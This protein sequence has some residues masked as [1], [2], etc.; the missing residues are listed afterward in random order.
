ML[1]WLLSASNH[2]RSARSGT[3]HYVHGL[4]PGPWRDSGNL[5]LDGQ[6]IA[7]RLD[8][9]F[10]L[11]T[12]GYRTVVR[13]QQTLEAT[14]ACSYELVLEPER[15]RLRCLSVFAGG[16]LLRAADTVDA[17]AAAAAAVHFPQQIDRPPAPGHD[18]FSAAAC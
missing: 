12:G 10:R 5:F 2:T 18:K 17:A 8:Q 11:L 14:I 7:G 9:R 6:L 13:R 15:A 1:R 16:W 3:T 4:Q